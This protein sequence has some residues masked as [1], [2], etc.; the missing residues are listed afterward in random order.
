VAPPASLLRNALG[1]RAEIV[2]KLGRISG[3]LQLYF[4]HEEIE[5]HFRSLEECGF[6]RE[7]P[8]GPQ[9]FVGGLD[10]LRFLIAP[11]ARNDYSALGISFGFH[12]L[13]RVLDDP[14]SMIDPT[15][16]FSARDTIVGHLMQVVHLNPVF[17]LQL[18][19]MFPDGLEDLEEQVAAMVALTHPR[20][21]TLGAIVE[22]PCYHRQLPDYIKRYRR[23]PTTPP[24][25]RRQQSL[26]SDPSFVRIEEQFATLPGF[27]EY[28][29][30]L[31][32][33]RWGLMAH[34]GRGRVASQ[35]PAKE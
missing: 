27:V 5:R 29:C 2:A 17:D 13:L 8:S 25:V 11:A 10:M 26:R 23:D 16:L 24:L 35:P 33:N 22:D 15:G 4:D 32:S 3:T 7:R 20:A 12:Q 28:C 30:R 6:I 21:R 9:L 19:Q 1:G 34:I 18:L 14:V 31:P